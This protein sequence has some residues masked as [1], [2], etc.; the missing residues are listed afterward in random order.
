MIEVWPV[1]A[2]KSRPEW[3]RK[4]LD[5]L[6]PQLR[7]PEH[8]VVVFDGDTPNH[9]D[10]SAQH[11]MRVCLSESVGVYRA[12]CLGNAYVPTDAV[13]CEIDDH[14]IAEPD[15]LA[16][17]RSAFADRAVMLAYCDVFHTDPAGTLRKTREKEDGLFRECGQ[18]GWGMRAY[19]KWAYDCVGGYPLD[20]PAAGDYAL[21]CRLE[22]FCSGNGAV[23]HIRKPLVTVLQSRD[24]IS[25]K[26][27]QEQTD[28]VSR[29]STDAVNGA[30]QHPYKLIGFAGED[31]PETEVIKPRSLAPPTSPEGDTAFEHTRQ[32]KA[33]I[34]KVTA[35]AQDEDV[36]VPLDSE[37]S[38]AYQ[39][40]L[41]LVTDYVGMGRGGGE[42]SMLGLLRKC[43]ETGH[44]ISALYVRDAG[45]EPEC[46][47]WIELHKVKKMVSVRGK[48]GE[49]SAVFTAALRKINPD[50]IITEA[51]TAANIV[52][53]AKSLGYPTLTLV[54]FWRGMVHG[55]KAFDALNSTE[56]YPASVRD[57]LGCAQIA[58]SAALVANS[59]FSALVTA[60]CTGREP[61]CV[62]Y[63]PVDGVRCVDPDAPPVPKRKY[64]TCLS[65]QSLKGIKIFIEL[66]R[67]RPRTQFLV[68][69]G[70]YQLCKE[71]HLVDE[72]E[73]LP[74]MTVRREWQTDM[75]AIYAQTR[76]LFIGTQ[77]CESFSRTAAEAR[78]NGIP[79]LVSDAG[80]L[81]NMAA[82]GYGQVVPRK[83]AIAEWLKGLTAATKLRPKPDLSM[84]QDHSPRFM[85]AIKNSR[86]LSEIV[87][88][89]PNAIGIKTGCEQFRRVLGLRVADWGQPAEDMADWPLV[90][91]PGIWNAK[92]AAELRG[93]VASWWC[94]HFAQMDSN[95]HEMENLLK[96]VEA[97]G[98][99]P[100]G[101]LLMTSEP[102]VAVWRRTLGEQVK[103]LPNC[104]ELPTD[105]PTPEKLDGTNVFIPGPYGV[106]KNVY[107][108]L[109]ACVEAGAD[110]HVTRL[111]DNATGF[112][113]LAS[114]LGVQL[115]VHDCPTVDDVHAVAGK[116]QAA[117]I[118]STAETFCYAA[119][120]CVLAGTP[121]ICPPGVPVM[122]GLSQVAV[123]GHVGYAGG[124]VEGVLRYSAERLA[125]QQETVRRNIQRYN[126]AARAT[127]LEVLDA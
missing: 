17:L 16:E 54:Q 8:I 109:A 56:P 116:C 3:L 120:E 31:I 35:G 67:R 64:V 105:L 106:R 25:K 87:I 80:N 119:A 126:L 63:P 26:R 75:A 47:D 76:V 57:K 33:I 91:T 90:I 2:T 51:G 94:S 7:R 59:E 102:D 123:P 125:E 29:I 32:P 20:H 100:R 68:V 86:K 70:D 103:W 13:V 101:Y 39:P 9:I 66:A 112:K 52:G 78:A 11:V 34:G 96:A 98:K 1:I 117:I 114:T 30:F 72:A 15:L 41:C 71:S 97:I 124:A 27:E 40:H 121:V 62:V 84:C 48:H 65:V 104:M 93:K 24:G 14:D 28:A 108:S 118:L 60:K 115:H 110:V 45:K 18:L 74:N 61:E 69:G 127:L 89:R 113:E 22:D 38:T 46:A 37:P 5:A 4:Q 95:R 44:R 77:T 73:S 107:A 111:I 42:L 43:Y 19:S 55:A 79:L 10:T 23:L 92:F 6:T 83:A 49:A 36:A 82:D 50:L 81:V 85:A 12:R 88:V 122:A 58:Q 21:M 99:H 53:A